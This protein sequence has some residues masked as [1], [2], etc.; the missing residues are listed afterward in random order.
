[1]KKFKK[2]KKNSSL[3][4]SRER[5]WN[6]HSSKSLKKSKM[7]ASKYMRRSSSVEKK[8]NAKKK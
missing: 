7:K 4:G 8:K 5:S 1:M 6:L 2:T 3:K